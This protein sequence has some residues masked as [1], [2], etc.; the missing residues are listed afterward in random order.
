M[1]EKETPAPKTGGLAGLATIGVGLAGAAVVGAGVFGAKSSLAKGIQSHESY[2][3]NPE[4]YN[5]KQSSGKFT[6]GKG[7]TPYGKKVTDMTVGEIR[8]RQGR[9]ELY[10]VGK[11][12]M[13]PSTMNDAV[14][15]GYLKDSD[16]FTDALQDRLFD[17]FITQKRPLV[18]KY[19]SG[20]PN[21]SREDAVLEIAKEWASVGVPY[22]MK[23]SRK[24]VK[25]GQSYYEGNGVDHASTSPDYIGALLDQHRSGKATLTL[26][27][28]TSGPSGA[29]IADQST[30]NAD[31]NEII[32]NE[33]VQNQVTN[34]TN[35]SVDQ[36]S[37]QTVGE[38][39]YDRSVYERKKNLK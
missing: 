10:A 12:Q 7:Q 16:P 13:I 30:R 38:P 19:L 5:I 36:S 15:K 28:S 26:D 8:E 18:G 11:W 9:G 6:G 29:S 27:N 20:D 23:G 33:Q 25:R 1:L 17:Y 4:A 37:Q 35:V 31:M 2:G 34:T 39:T 14:A 21:V 3:G 24:E 32:K 22:D